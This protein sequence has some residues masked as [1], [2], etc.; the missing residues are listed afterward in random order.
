[1]APPSPEPARARVTQL[2]AGI[3][4]ICALAGVVVYLL[5]LPFLPFQDIPNHVLT[6]MIHDGG[7]GVAHEPGDF[8][9]TYHG[10]T[11][12]AG[13]SQLWT[14]LLLP[15]PDHNGPPAPGDPVWIG[16][17]GYGVLETTIEELPALLAEQNRHREARNLAPLPDLTGLTHAR[18]VIAPAP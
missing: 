17:S 12:N 15:D 8:V 6:M 16:T 9:F 5:W 3:V 13:D 18:P 2:A 14:V 11:P 1:M 4:A 10:A 7:Y